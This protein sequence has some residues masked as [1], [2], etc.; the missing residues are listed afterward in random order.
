MSRPQSLFA[1]AVLTGVWLVAV[2]T[3][4]RPTHIHGLMAPEIVAYVMQPRG[5]LIRPAEP[6]DAQPVAQAANLSEDDQPPVLAQQTDT[7]DPEAQVQILM[8]TRLD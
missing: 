3:M 4:N 1:L 8:L 5:K 2:E 7:L 6:Q